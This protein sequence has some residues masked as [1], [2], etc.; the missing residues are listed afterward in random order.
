MSVGRS[1]LLAF[2]FL[3]LGTSPVIGENQL[4]PS[5]G[6]NT[7][8]ATPRPAGFGTTPYH[9]ASVPA[10]ADGNA[11]ATGR[12]VILSIA[13]LLVA[14]NVILGK[15]SKREVSGKLGKEPEYATRDELN[16]LKEKVEALDAKLDRD[17]DEILKAG[18]M[19][20][21]KLHGRIDI[22]VAQMGEVRGELKHIAALVMKGTR[23]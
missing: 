8:A 9:L 15:P 23:E 6:G 11:L 12:D 18:E 17:R 20:A 5:T 19:R 22:L 7:A 14:L 21:G 2:A 1:A 13:G 10:S 16:E 4:P 3:I